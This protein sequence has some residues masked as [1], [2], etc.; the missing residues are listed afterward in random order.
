MIERIEKGVKHVQND[1]TDVNLMSFLLTLNI[2]Y[3]LLV[4]LSGLM[5][6]N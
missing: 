4:L 3:A 5:L 1:V 6:E 2:F